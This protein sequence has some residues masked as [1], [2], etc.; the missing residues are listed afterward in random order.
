MTIDSLKQLMDEF[1][2]ASLLPQLDTLVGK[3]ELVMR[4]AVMVGPVLLLLLGIVYLFLSPRE[5]NY[6]L[7]YRCYFGMGSVNAWRYA[8][9][10]AGIVWGVL[11]LILTVVMLLICSKFRG[12]EAMD[13][14]GSA[15]KCVLWEAGLI[16]LSCIGINVTLA[17]VYDAKG[18]LR[19][20]KR[21]NK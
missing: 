21:R 9:K 18:E 10:L 17:C 8:Q 15:V 14:L 1:D 3:V 19:R 20:K 11:G 12:M 4:I 16:V 2:P 6:Y 5:A 7:G 13:M